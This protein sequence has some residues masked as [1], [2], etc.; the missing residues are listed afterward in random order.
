[1]SQ[2]ITNTDYR[3]LLSLV[4]SSRPDGFAEGKELVVL[5]GKLMQT[6]QAV[7]TVELDNRVAQ[8]VAA[9]EAAVK[10]TL[11][12]GDIPPTD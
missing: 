8:A 9:K 7:Q 12:D 5:E 4:R 3:N 6:L 1:M 10:E 11:L 2:F